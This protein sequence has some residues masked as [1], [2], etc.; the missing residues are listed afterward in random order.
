VIGDS[1]NTVFRI[2]DYT[3]SWPNSILIS[4]KTRQSVARFILDVREIGT[5][6]A[7]D[8]SSALKIYELLGC[9]KRE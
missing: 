1:V 3:K 6:N 9:R 8:V 4:E 7:G 2:Q 5:Y